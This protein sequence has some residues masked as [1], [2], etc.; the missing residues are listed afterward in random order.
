[1]LGFTESGPSQD[2]VAQVAPQTPGQGSP[3]WC[4][5]QF[6]NKSHAD[7]LRLSWVKAVHCLMTQ[8]GKTGGLGELAVGTG[9]C[10]PRGAPGVAH[11][12]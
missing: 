9:Q 3:S 8:P 7:A 12:A 4:R 6:S 11:V 5:W 1:M 2:E 10:G